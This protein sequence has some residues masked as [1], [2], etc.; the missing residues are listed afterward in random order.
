MGGIAR[1][2]ASSF[3]WSLISAE[4][5]A[6]RVVQ[7]DCI[8]RTYRTSLFASCDYVV[9]QVWELSWDR[10]TLLTSVKY[11]AFLHLLPERSWMLH[12]RSLHCWILKCSV[13][14]I[15]LLPRAKSPKEIRYLRQQL[16]QIHVHVLLM[17]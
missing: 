5:W 16:L 2:S 3:V 6:I 14:D 9:V 13:E 12:L 11:T 15:L 17:L 8:L 7:G 10:V 1:P 4:V